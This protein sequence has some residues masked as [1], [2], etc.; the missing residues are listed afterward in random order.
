M[1]FKKIKNNPIDPTTD[2]GYTPETTISNPYP[3]SCSA[4]SPSTTWLDFYPRLP[5][6]C[7][8]P[9]SINTDAQLS[10]PETCKSH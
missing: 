3:Q 2:F 7:V 10:K 9:I 4:L 8:F 6:Y 5:T 1:N